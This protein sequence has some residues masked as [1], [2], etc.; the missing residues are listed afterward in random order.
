MPISVFKKLL[1]SFRKAWTGG[2]QFS[3][4]RIIFDVKVYLRRKSRLV[5]GGHVVDSSEHDKHHEVIF[6]QDP[7]DNRG[8]KKLEVMTY[9]IGNAYFN[10]NTEK[11]IFTRLGT[12]FY[13]V[14]I[15][16]EGTLLEVVQALYGL[17][18]SGNR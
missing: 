8:R 5:I 4:L 13:L 15:M 10:V 7:N 14:G 1:S 9:Y 18:T 6:S 17:T 2:Y 11:N 16:S 3:P 12:D